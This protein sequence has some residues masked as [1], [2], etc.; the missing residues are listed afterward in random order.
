VLA[1][2]FAP[3]P[4][5]EI[6]WARLLLARAWAKLCAPELIRARFVGFAKMRLAAMWFSTMC[7]SSVGLPA[8]RFSAVGFSKTGL[9]EVGFARMLFPGAFVRLTVAALR[10]F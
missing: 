8:M 2:V 7:F 6:F 4:A 5:V 10:P 1:P 3:V 9:P